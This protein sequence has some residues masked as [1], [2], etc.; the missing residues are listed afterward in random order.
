MAVV[1]NLMVRCGADFS[2]LTEGS[3]KGQKSVQTF[4]K[5][6]S[7]SMGKV[8]AV[9]GKVAIAAAAA[10]SVGA[11]VNF[12]KQSVQAATDL[13]NAMIG[14]QSIIDGQG[15]S[16]SQAK[17][18]INE[19][20]SDGLVPATEAITA[21]KNL[22][23]R[24][25]DDSQIQ[26]VLVALK[27]S[28][29]FGRQASYSMG[30][31]VASA[32]EGLKN[33][34]SILVDNAGVTKN[35]AKMWE[36]YAK[37]IGTTANKL[38]QAQKIQ[39]EV[40]GIL[41]ETRFQSGDAAKVAKTFSGQIQKLQFNFNSLKVAIGNAI[42]PLA[43]R[44]LPVINNV[45]TML[46][47]LAERAALVSEL[48]FGK[49]IS[50]A[51]S[52]TKA[53][54]SQSDLAESIEEADKAA[55]GALASFDDLNVLQK[56]TGA[57]SGA[58]TSGANASPLSIESPIAE[59]I[60]LPDNVVTWAENIKKKFEEVKP[61]FDTLKTSWDTL[62]TTI[63]EFVQDPYVKQI[64]G[65]TSEFISQSVI[66]N[67]KGFIN[68]LSGGLLII[69][70][71]IKIT[72]GWW[73]VFIGAITSNP[74]KV[75]K[76]LS[77]I[78]S[79]VLDTTKGIALAAKGVIEAN[80]ISTMAGIATKDTS[81]E[82]W[83]NEKVAPNYEPEKWDGLFVKSK[84]GWETG[85]AKITSWWDNSAIGSWWNEHVAPWFTAG[86]WEVVIYNSIRGWKLAWK[87][88]TTWWNNSAIGKWWSD[89]VVPWFTAEQW[90]SVWQDVGLGWRMG[91]APVKRW[92]KDSAIGNWWDNYVAPWFTQKKW[93]DLWDDV[94]A[95]WKAGWK[96]ISDWWNNSAIGKL[97][98][99]IG[100]AFNI[101]VGG[102]FG[103]DVSIPHLA[104]GAVI[105]PNSNFLAM[106]GDQSSGQNL[107]LPE[108]LLRQIV[109]EEGG[110]KIVFDGPEDIMQL[111]RLLQPRFAQE[112]TRRGGNLIKG[113]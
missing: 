19:Y 45:V 80:P 14:L 4:Q 81:I 22:A 5:N 91:W 44:V 78:D 13:S 113:V 96:T 103:G 16:F 51:S 82:D 30:E 34:N 111:V 41:E 95:A 87:S 76:G 112:D 49:K 62:K 79:G 102:G 28:A 27:D 31:A 59:D 39:A 66:D 33:E 20:I 40:N 98:E 90:E 10:F 71:S 18:F 38:T 52:G 99:K 86:Q 57:L 6:V 64:L 100:G 25:Y 101:N 77:L 92:W 36:D 110:G 17:A 8:K 104:T 9:F 12:G 83:Y 74:E 54:E 109:R 75:K 94:L 93:I 37:S 56:D 2:A 46:T 23:L 63:G 32:S 21:Y 48:L 43:E 26:Q 69:S 50:I 35:V 1:K 24:G 84:S 61:S 73:Y 29:A 107:E 47:R 85:W 3:K 72:L 58:D 7:G 105:P 11:I 53:A 15:R 67:I 42:M 89:N 55:K 108:G 97:F 106:L 88:I 65:I 60:K 70:G 68:V